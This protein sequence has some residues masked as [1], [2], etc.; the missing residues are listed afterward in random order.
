MAV[1]DVHDPAPLG[2]WP[3]K[4]RQY[5][6]VEHHFE[7]W[8]HPPRTTVWLVW[9]NLVEVS[10]GTVYEALGEECWPLAE[11]TTREQEIAAGL[12]VV[13]AEEYA[14]Q[15]AALPPIE[16]FIVDSGAGEPGSSVGR[17][18]ITIPAVDRD[19]VR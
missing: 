5:L 6:R 17:A 7:S 19:R 14:A 11:C 8:C 4:Y 18:S 15:L 2:P 1:A 16:F 10:D 12:P 9:R 13:T 3:V